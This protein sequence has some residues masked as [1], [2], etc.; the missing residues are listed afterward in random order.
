[1]KKFN[2]SFGIGLTLLILVV[3]FTQCKK[4]DS[5]EGL[6]EGF[7][8][9]AD[10]VPNLL[11]DVRYY[12]N[13]NFVGK[14]IN[15]Y[16]K[17][18]TISTLEAAIALKKVQEE[19]EE[20]NYRLKIFDGYRPQRGVDHF[21]EWSHNY[22]DTLTKAKF[23]P[24]IKKSDLFDLN[25]LAKRSG[26]S[27]GSTYDLS[28]IDADGNELDM[29]T[30]WDYFGP[31]SWPTDTTISKLAQDNRNLLRGLMLKYGFVPYTE[32]WWHFTLDNEP[33]PD[34]YFDFLNE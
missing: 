9:V 23:Y 8:Y 1:M 34:T 3:L 28:I 29:G 32:E 5:D 27:R 6:P 16:I 7:V 17:P 22:S 11:I 19:L 21:I 26:H 33:Y 30:T 24:K 25:Y 12:S 13:D 15:G 18:V 2:L 31:E 14:R 10:I 4:S 20:D